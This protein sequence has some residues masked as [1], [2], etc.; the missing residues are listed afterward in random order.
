MIRYN[1]MKVGIGFEI[2][3]FENL[4]KSVKA[5]AAMPEIDRVIFN[6]PATIVFWADGSKTIVKC[7]NEEFDPEKGLA[8]AFVKRALG[9]KGNYYE[10]FRDNIPNE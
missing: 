3:E 9:N 4:M 2:E 8:M 10:I 5:K 7:A 6:D 1:N